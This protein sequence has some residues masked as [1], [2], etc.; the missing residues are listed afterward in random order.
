MVTR[1]HPPAQW[2]KVTGVLI[3]LIVTGIAAACATSRSN[4]NLDG[5]SIFTAN[6]SSCHTI[7]RGNLAGPDLKGVIVQQGRDWL[8]K[9]ISNPDQVITSGDPIANKLLQEYDYVVMPNLGLT[10]EQITAV[11]DYIQAESGALVPTPVTGAGLPQGDAANGRK[12]F[13]GE[14]KLQNG[15][16]FCIGCHGIDDTGILGGGTL[17]PNLTDA[18]TKYGDAGLEGILSNLPFLTMRPIFS[19]HTP[20]ASERADIRAFLKST[21]G[22]PQVNKEPLVIGIALAGFV[23]LMAAIGFYWR[24]RLQGVRQKLVSQ[25]RSRK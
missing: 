6:C 22:Q 15:G 10:R 14:V 21:A 5:Q 24:N 25:A 1:Y 8:T 12:I 20:T 17:G 19:N 23:M 13:L 9:F 2:L 4:I 7:G 11:L 18:Y 16:P 3:T